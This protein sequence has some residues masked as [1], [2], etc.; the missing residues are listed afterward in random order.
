MCGQSSVARN[1]SC[2]VPGQ[3]L[4]AHAISSTQPAS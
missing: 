1:R 3:F 4:R 2:A